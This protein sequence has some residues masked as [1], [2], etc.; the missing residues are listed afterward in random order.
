VVSDVTYSPYSA[1]KKK[2]GRER[3]SSAQKRSGKLS[4][5]RGR[6]GLSQTPNPAAP[7]V[8][9]SFTAGQWAAQF[10][11]ALRDRA[12]IENR[13]A[14]RWGSATGI[15]EPFFPGFRKRMPDGDMTYHLSEGGQPGLADDLDAQHP[16]DCLLAAVARAGLTVRYVAVPK[17]SWPS[18]FDRKEVGIQRFYKDKPLSAFYT[19]SHELA[20]FVLH[21]KRPKDPDMI[22]TETRILEGYLMKKCIDDVGYPRPVYVTIRKPAP[23]DFEFLAQEWRPIP[24]VPPVRTRRQMVASR[25]RILN[26]AAMIEDLFR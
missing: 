26:A 5:S 13:M 11:T 25:E 15:F 6:P 8:S 21:R 10:E 1:E 9:V 24:Y 19:V 2:E 16:L 3:T 17:P 14:R 20:H 7:E 23:P 18:L 4:R 12:E 22:E